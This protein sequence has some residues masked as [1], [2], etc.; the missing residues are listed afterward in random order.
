MSKILTHAAVRS[1]LVLLSPAL[2]VPA[3]GDQAEQKPVSRELS[4]GESIKVTVVAKEKFNPTGVKAAAG[5]HFSFTI[6]KGARWKDLNIVCDANGWLSKD[7]PSLTRKFIQNA[8]MDR[9]V[10]AANWFELVG[11]VGANEDHHFQI[12]LRGKD[13][14][15]TVKTDGE[16]FLFANDL[17]KY[18][19]NNHDSIEVTVTRKATA[20]KQQLPKNPETP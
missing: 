19:G 14:T 7:A 12:G 4:V 9:R 20:G 16:L 15:H 6:A 8:E 3:V 5:Q 1:L 17:I 11:T 10:P 13:W 2:T 18:Y